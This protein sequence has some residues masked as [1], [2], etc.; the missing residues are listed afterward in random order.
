MTNKINEK[1]KELIGRSSFLD[2]R[3][4][5]SKLDLEKKI[6][7]IVDGDFTYSLS[8]TTRDIMHELGLWQGEIID[9]YEIENYIKEVEKIRIQ[10]SEIGGE[11]PFANIGCFLQFMGTQKGI[12][13]DSC[14]VIEV[15]MYGH[16][17]GYAFLNENK[18]YTLADLR[19]R[20]LK[21]RENFSLV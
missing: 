15:I 17:Y 9:D 16:R 6:N 21:D 8:E 19:E 12:A 1:M 2:Y 5:W 13:L 20:L 11:R 10:L 4:L 14:P 7:Y 18:I 3:E